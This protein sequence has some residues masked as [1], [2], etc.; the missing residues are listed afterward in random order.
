M[1][2]KY[3]ESSDGVTHYCGFEIPKLCGSYVQRLD[4]GVERDFISFVYKKEMRL[5]K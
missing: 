3:L 4:D 5:E 1:L 2:N